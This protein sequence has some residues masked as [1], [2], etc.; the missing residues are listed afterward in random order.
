VP[1]QRLDPVVRRAALGSEVALRYDPECERTL[2]ASS[3]HLDG[4]T[5]R[6][7]LEHVD[8]AEVQGAG[9]RHH[10]GAV[11]LDGERYRHTGAVRRRAKLR[12]DPASREKRRE[13]AS[14]EILDL[15]QSPARF[16]LQFAEQRPRSLEVTVERT[17]RGLEVDREPDKILL[18]ALVQGALDISTISVARG[19]EARA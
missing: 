9:D 17:R 3:A 13:D 7:V 5:C 1:A 19:R 12:N 6:Y 10:D 16:A 2:L 18:H 15:R 11:Q 8:G 14:G 4:C